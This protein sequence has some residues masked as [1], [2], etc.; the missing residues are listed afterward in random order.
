[1][2]TGFDVDLQPEAEG[3]N[4]FPL[5]NAIFSIN[6]GFTLDTPVS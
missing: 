1:M 5:K 6:L 2:G 3:L 4:P